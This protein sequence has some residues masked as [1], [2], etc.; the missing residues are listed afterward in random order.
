MSIINLN[1]HKG[2]IFQI[3]KK[4]QSKYPS[5]A[6]EDIIQE[7]NL[8]VLKY[9]DKY[10]SSKGTESTFIT[11]FVGL[12][13]NQVLIYNY[14]N[15]TYNNEG[16][17][18]E[19]IFINKCSINATNEDNTGEL[20]DTLNIVNAHND[21]YGNTDNEY[22]EVQEIIEQSNLSDIEKEIVLLK[23]GFKGE[24][25][26]LEAIGQ[27]LGISKQAIDKRLDRIEAKLYC[28]KQLRELV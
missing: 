6:L 18:R 28:N 3:A 8:L 12:K 11:N 4:M 1:N 7:I 9:A 24:P 10:D 25:M 16:E 23:N 17:K 14:L 21:I 13:I 27:K 20:A 2:I 26:T 22:S 19:R 5:I 15:F